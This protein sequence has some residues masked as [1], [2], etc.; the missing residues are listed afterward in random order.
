MFRF[1]SF[2][3]EIAAAYGVGLR[4]DFNYF[5]LRFDMGM[6][7]HN[8]ALGQEPWP[9]DSSG[10]APRP[11]LPFFHRLSFLS[12]LTPIDIKT[13][14]IEKLVIFDLDGTLLNTIADLG[15]ACSYALR[16]LGF[17]EHALP[18]YRYMV[19]NGVRKLIRT[20]RAGCRRG[21][22]GTSSVA[23]PANTTENTQQTTHLL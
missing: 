20:R 5:L 11:L 21:N 17:P 8:P 1:N 2:Y 16:T 12:R 6:K 23:L 10:L 9:P 22:R 13:D 3:K 7:A 14:P 4:L 15:N 18:T 19:G